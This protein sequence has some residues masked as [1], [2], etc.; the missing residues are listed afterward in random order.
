M[1]AGLCQATASANTRARQLQQETSVALW[2]IRYH[3]YTHAHLFRCM[4]ALSS[5]N[6]T[7]LLYSCSHNPDYLHLNLILLHQ[8]PLLLIRQLFTNELTLLFARQK[9][10]LPEPPRCSV[11]LINFL[12]LLAFELKPQY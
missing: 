8:L 9:W 7:V 11:C 4:S 6:S 12:L 10:P 5:P 1:F 2:K 3:Y